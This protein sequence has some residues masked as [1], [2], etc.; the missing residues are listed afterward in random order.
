MEEDIDVYLSRIWNESHLSNGRSQPEQM[1]DL[2]RVLSREGILTPNKEDIALAEIGPFKLAV[3]PPKD[4]L[5]KTFF[6]EAVP[7][8]IRVFCGN[9]DLGQ[10]LQDFL[11]PAFQGLAAVVRSAVRISE[12]TTWIV[13]AYIKSENRRGRFPAIDDINKMLA[14]ISGVNAPADAIKNILESLMKA[15]PI[16]GSSAVSLVAERAGGGFES[17]A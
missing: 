17:R 16:V 2:C 6:Q 14:K 9:I 13:L 5:V 15:K 4:V 7:T 12:P 3:A 11:I 8:I 1:W 10:A